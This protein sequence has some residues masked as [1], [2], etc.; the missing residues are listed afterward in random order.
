MSSEPDRRSNPSDPPRTA[1][2]DADA[3]Q[4]QVRKAVALHYQPGAAAPRVVAT[5][6]GHVAEQIID[7]AHEAGVPVREDRALANAL[8]ALELDAEVPEVL[9]RAVAETL[10]WAYSLDTAAARRPH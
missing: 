4:T 7:A 5:G 3:E 10:A 8:A 1:G 9:Y 6:R 2:E